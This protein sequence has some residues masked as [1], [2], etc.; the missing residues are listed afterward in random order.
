M[1]AIRSNDRTFRF[2]AQTADG[3][4]TRGYR[5]GATRRQVV[6]DLLGEGLHVTD[7]REGRRWDIQIGT[8]KADRAAVM[9]F[10]HQLAA[11]V[12]AGV[13]L[14]EALE[15]VHDEMA[16]KVLRNVLA[17]VGDSLRSGMPFADAVAVHER[18]FPPYYVS[19][20]RSAEMT[21]RL[22][23][24]LDQL[25]RD[26]GRDLDARRKLQGA[27]IYPA[28]IFL[29]SI[30]AVVVLTV[31]VLPKFRT[32]FE[33]FDARLPLATR[34][35]IAVTD[36]VA[37]WGWAVA[38]G[39][40]VTTVATVAYCRTA[41]GRLRRDR[42]VL[43]L[44]IV[45][46]VVEDAAVERFCR[47]LSSM[48]QAGV[49][50]PDALQL[51]SAGTNNRVYQDA[52]VKA[53]EEMIQGEGLSGPIGRTGVFPSAVTQML[54][55]GEETGTLSDQLDTMSSYF[56]QELDFRL[57]NLTTVF[58]P[59]VIVSVGLMVGFVAIALVSA[60]YGV[61]NQVDV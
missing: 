27:V 17:D 49:P 43:R 54:R 29:L 60:M 9:H 22:D 36:F 46:P 35:L 53:R 21:G 47:V 2:H 31:F 4:A 38:L 51:A 24:V 55:V 7:L 50:L 56:A 5:S 61:Y 16:D 19:I 48:A 20:L 58:E 42:V 11:F 44:P 14:I 12:R 13:P 25:G 3:H 37:D 40:A 15:V 28:L 30:V 33:S 32:F 39:I 18:V 34:M 26:I 57:K 45:G 52:L 8:A 10:S 1:T 23:D 6:N 41:G 59:A